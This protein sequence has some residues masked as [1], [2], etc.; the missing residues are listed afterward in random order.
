MQQD[1]HFYLLQATVPQSLF[2]GTPAELLSYSLSGDHTASASDRPF[3][4]VI[5]P[6]THKSFFLQSSL[7]SQSSLTLGSF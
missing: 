6:D 7:M 5:F 3:Y 1:L 4:Q 2:V